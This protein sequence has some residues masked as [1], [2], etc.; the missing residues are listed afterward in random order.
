MGDYDPQRQFFWGGD[1][2]MWF[3]DMD[4]YARH[5]LQICSLSQ[6]YFQITVLKSSP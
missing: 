5:S 1:R 4:V 6:R 2:I 3:W